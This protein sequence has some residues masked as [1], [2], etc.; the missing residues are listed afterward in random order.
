M[1]SRKRIKYL[2]MVLEDAKR[3]EYKNDDR[4]SVIS[5]LESFLKREELESDYWHQQI[6]KLRFGPSIWTGSTPTSVFVQCY[7]S[8]KADL[9]SIIEKIIRQEEFYLEEG[10]TTTNETKIF[11]DGQFFD[12]TSYIV[13]IVKTAKSKIVLVD[14]YVS[15]ET[16][17]ILSNKISGVHLTVVTYSSSQLSNKE[18]TSF[19]KQ[20]GN[21]SVYKT[22]A[23]HDRFLIVDDTKCYQI[24]SSI[25]DAGNKCFAIL[26]ITDNFSVNSLIKRIKLEVASIT[27]IV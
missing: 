19:N 12:A 5:S 6:E 18:I 20:Y 26:E 24:G 21:L 1:D 3:L 14:G 13:G 4:L 11:F 2:N 15:N 27:P 17:D 22:Q 9:I 10:E 8:G 16:L 23:F 7:N 25:K